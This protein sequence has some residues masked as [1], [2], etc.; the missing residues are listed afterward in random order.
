M[1]RDIFSKFRVQ[2]EEEKPEKVKDV[3]YNYN[4]SFDNSY[5]YTSNLYKNNSRYRV[6]GF[7]GKVLLND[8]PFD[9][10]ELRK[11][12]SNMWFMSM[13]ENT[14]NDGAYVFK[15]DN[16]IVSIGLVEKAV[17]TNEI[18]TAA[19][20]NYMWV[21]GIIESSEHKAHLKVSVMGEGSPN[22]KGII[23]VKVMSACCE[24]SSVIGIYTNGTVY[25]T[26]VYK[27]LADIMEID[28]SPLPVLNLVWIG[29]TRSENG[30]NVYTNGLK[31]FYKDEMEI[32]DST[33]NFNILHSVMVDLVN[34]VL[35]NDVTFIDGET[36]GFRP[37]QNWLITKSDGVAADGM[38][39]KIDYTF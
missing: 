14:N 37:E 4:N 2:L 18:Q 21:E 1:L 32:V 38:T 34:Y 16:S 7:K 23:F 8:Q 10:N 12:L 25:K 22:E 33:E 20:K 39:L 29:F 30:L 24:Q 27:E 5:K 36:F 26:D 9:F 35:E 13:N 15:V 17:P 28:H 3:A 11:D 31:A 6:R 19:A